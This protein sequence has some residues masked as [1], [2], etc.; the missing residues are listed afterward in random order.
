MLT[1]H[2]AGLT[3]AKWQSS[4]L[5]ASLVMLR[6]VAGSW[7]LALLCVGL[8]ATGSLGQ[9]QYQRPMPPRVTPRAGGNPPASPRMVVPPRGR[10]GM[11]PAGRVV[12]PRPPTASPGMQAPV[13]GRTDM[14]IGRH[15]GTRRVKRAGTSPPIANIPGKSPARVPRLVRQAIR[16]APANAA[17]FS[18]GLRSNPGRNKPSNIRHD[19]KHK[20]GKSGWMHGHRPFFF[21]HAGHRWRRHYYSF[22]I[23]GLWYWYWYDVEADDDPTAVVYGDAALP[24]CDPDI[25]DCVEPELIAPAILEGRA[26]ED[27]MAHCT[28][29]FR[30]FDARTGTYVARRGEVRVCP[31]LE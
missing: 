9:T 21:K 16:K 12:I 4:V 13:T 18:R 31:Y 2:R 24:D 1:P 5:R 28:A 15:Q 8:T 23:G 14:I 30:S 10:V 29:E 11:P 6:I 17:L 26:T 22:F 25:D 7:T 19:P 3:I 20:A 27:A